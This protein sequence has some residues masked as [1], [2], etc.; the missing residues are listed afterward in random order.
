MDH[1]RIASGVT[2]QQLGY[3]MSAVNTGSLSSA[4]QEHFISQPSLSDQIRRLERQLGVT[5]FIRTNRT[6][7]LTD[8]A[9]S[10][11]PHAERTLASAQASI[12]SVAPVR[13]LT[14]GTVTFGT[15]STGHLLFQAD[16]VEGFHRLH[17]AVSLRL[18]STNSVQ[19]AEEVREGRLEAAVVALPVNDRGLDI[20][21]LD[22]TPETVYLSANPE[23]TA[24][25]MTMERLSQTR[26][27]MP[28][29][30][31]GDS[32][33]T[34]LRLLLNAQR[35]GHAIS[36]QFEVDSP[37]SALELTSRGVADTVLTYTLAHELGMLDSLSYCSLDPVLTENFG[38][39]RR[40]NSDLSPAATVLVDLIK[41]LLNDLP[42]TGT[43]TSQ[44]TRG[45]GTL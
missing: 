21:P 8:A 20:E 27:V 3:F 30:L 32:D 37:A 7:I 10:L 16:L 40:Q 38:I 12:D 22:W 34:R 28:E 11:V 5:L 41:K 24:K 45:L 18:V 2:L 36:S 39:I 4:A 29:I 23:R 26:L 13:D 14:G 25:P 43:Q 17:P 33:P 31:W 35:T 19:I 42:E 1:A 9:K 44:T 15:F 6:L